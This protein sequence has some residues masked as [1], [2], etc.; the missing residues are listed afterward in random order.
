[1]EWVGLAGLNKGQD[2]FNPFTFHRS[3]MNDPVPTGTG[4]AMVS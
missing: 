3:A 1:M 4:G 2:S